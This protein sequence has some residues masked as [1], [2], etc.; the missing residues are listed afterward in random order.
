MSLHKSFL[1]NE[2]MLH[3]EVIKLFMLDEDFVE[4]FDIFTFNA[5]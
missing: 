3:F 5:L 4:V 2:I 1:W